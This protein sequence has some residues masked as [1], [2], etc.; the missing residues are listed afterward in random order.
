MYY[1]ELSSSVAISF[2]REEDE[3][4]FPVYFTQGY[5]AFIGASKFFKVRGL[6]LPDQAVRYQYEII[7]AE[8]AGIGDTNSTLFVISLK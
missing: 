1:D 2:T 6:K 3:G 5:G 7:S 8:S 4:A